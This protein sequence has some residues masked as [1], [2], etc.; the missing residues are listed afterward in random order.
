[1]CCLRLVSPPAVG[2]LKSL[3]GHTIAFV[4]VEM[5][6]SCLEQKQN[7]NF[8]R[9]GMLADFASQVGLEGGEGH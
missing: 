6:E 8:E 7:N 4:S 9:R 2:W 3:Q 1:M 5:L